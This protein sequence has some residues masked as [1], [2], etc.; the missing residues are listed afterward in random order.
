MIFD[1]FLQFFLGQKNEVVTSGVQFHFCCLFQQL[2]VKL[3]GYD[4]MGV[5]AVPVR[6]GPAVCGQLHMGMFQDFDGLGMGGGYSP[7]RP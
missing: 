1:I 7:Q 5:L 4:T 3:D 6:F 2:R